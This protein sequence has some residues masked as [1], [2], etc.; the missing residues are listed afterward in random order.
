MF[1]QDPTLFPE[2]LE[3]IPKRYAIDK[4]NR[5]M[6]EYSDAI[7]SYVISGY[8]GAAKY[9]NLAVRRGK[10]IYELSE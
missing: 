5:W 9:K 1:L 7:I 6:I 2:S 8:G 3:F 4:R 10:M